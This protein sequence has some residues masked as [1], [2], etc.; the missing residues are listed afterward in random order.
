MSKYLLSFT[1][2]S[3]MPYETGVI[4]S[5]YGKYKDWDRVKKSVV[6]DNIIQKNTLSTRK[7]IFSELKRRVDN[8]TKE[9]LEYCQ[10]ASSEDINRLIFLSVNKTYKFIKEFMVEVVRKKA[11]ML[12]YKILNSDYETFFESKA[13]SSEQFQNIS[14]TTRYKIKQV[15]FKIL[16]E[17]GI[18]DNTKTKNIQKIY[19]N[20]NLIKLIIKGNPQYLKVFLLSD[21]QIEF[22]KGKYL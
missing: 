13:I 14:D 21:E 1:A 20:E 18:I 10:N 17:A 4:I 3:L 9:E 2:A 8:L 7:R 6:E 16:Q 22:F 19:L 12:D 11:L 15:L 5:E